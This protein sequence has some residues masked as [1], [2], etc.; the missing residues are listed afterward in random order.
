MLQDAARGQLLPWQ[1]A[2]LESLAVRGAPVLPAPVPAVSAAVWNVVVPLPFT[3]GG[4]SCSVWAH[5]RLQA[6]SFP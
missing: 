2:G 4:D 1:W 6:H 5:A 3:D